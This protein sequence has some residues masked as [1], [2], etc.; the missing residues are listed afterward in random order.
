[1]KSITQRVIKDLCE[2]SCFLEPF[3]RWILIKKIRVTSN[4]NVLIF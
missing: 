4:K 3:V 2:P 1:M